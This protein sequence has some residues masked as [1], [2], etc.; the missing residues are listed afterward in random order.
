M[1]S[2]GYSASRN[3]YPTNPLNLKFKTDI[4][5]FPPKSWWRI[6]NRNTL[7]SD[8]IAGITV[9]TILLTQSV[10]F[11]IIAGLPPEYGLYSAIVIS[12]VAAI[13]GSSHHLISGPTTP[14]SL[15]VFAALSPLA[16]INTPE[17]IQLAFSLAF[18]V[19]GFQLLLGFLGLG[20][21]INFISRSVLTGFTAGA[22]ILIATSQMKD[23]L[24]IEI[25]SGS[26]F[27][28]TWYSIFEQLPQTNQYVF[29]I[30][31][32]TIIIAVVLKKIW[33]R[34]PNL[35]IALISTSLLTYYWGAKEKGILLI[36]E[37]PSHLPPLSI[38]DLSVET[39]SKLSS[40]AFAVALLG[41]IQAVSI[42]QAVGIQSKQN[43]NNNQEFF[44]QGMSNIVASF[45]SGYAGTGSFT[46]TAINTESGARTPLAAIF[47]AI[48]LTIA[49]LY[50]TPLAAYLP[51]ASLGGVI[52]LVAWQLLKWNSIK[53]I[54]A[55]SK[56]EAVVLLSTLFATLF[57]SLELAIYSGV[58]LSLVFYLQKTSQ[59]RVA[60]IAPNP[61]LPNQKF[62]N[63]ERFK[64]HE[65]PQL[66]VI[67]IDGSLYFGAVSHIANVF[68]EIRANNEHKN[69][70]IIGNGIN[71]IDISGLELLV[72][73]ANNW[74]DRGGQLF[75]SGLRKNAFKYIKKGNYWQTIGK[76]NFFLSKKDAI[77][78][79]YQQ[80]DEDVCKSCKARIFI[81]CKA[82]KLEQLS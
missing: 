54:I 38:P 23:V 70:L 62:V 28:A 49:I 3:Q 56:S 81:E 15:M 78:A 73:E 55:T 60:I 39:M 22:A 43:I 17:Y 46:R 7:K 42:A 67:R 27:F 58:I 10:A 18:L 11:A 1:I 63:I 36:G 80:L 8:F 4:N 9:A 29:A 76:D 71:Q 14:L 66:K 74:R 2:W 69:L 21:L 32:L 40:P 20:A 47:A 77:A 59:P 52:L 37:L 64:V 50:I 30:G 45:F 53:M 57:L 68:S 79:I 31:I 13:F 25:P 48:F 19:G 26:S 24:G 61:Q 41:L 34:S 12:I 44:G 65:C 82:K 5:L 75:F 16:E 72:Q 6:I 33:R 35:L 51:Y